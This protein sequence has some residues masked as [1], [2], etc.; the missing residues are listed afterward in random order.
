MEPNWVP[1][2]GP[3]KIK[4]GTFHFEPSQ[5]VGLGAPGAPDASGTAKTFPP[6]SLVRSN[7]SFE[8]GSIS[9]D[10]KVTDPAATVQIGMNAPPE[11]EI[12]GGVNS[13]GAL[14][15]FGMFRSASWE[16][17]GGTGAEVR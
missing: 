13:L 1:L 8:Q 5:S 11:G 12:Y 17:A 16:G 4:D 10:F 9:F 15:G 7:I 6:H 3:V 14:Y 2:H